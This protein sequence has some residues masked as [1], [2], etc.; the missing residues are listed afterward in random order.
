VTA[1]IRIAST[2]EDVVLYPNDVA[3]PQI[4]GRQRRHE[5]LL[6]LPVVGLARLDLPAAHAAQLSRLG[7][8]H[9]APGHVLDGLRKDKKSA[10]NTSFF[11]CGSDDE[12]KWW[13]KDE[14]LNWRGK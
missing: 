12:A 3:A 7:L 9:L 1:K 8:H 11:C 5:E 10:L 6:V 2:Y 13:G 4:G 14:G